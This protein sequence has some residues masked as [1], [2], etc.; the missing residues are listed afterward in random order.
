MVLR[1]L[2]YFR[3]A[4]RPWALFAVVYIVAW[5]TA[6]AW[7][8]LPWV[9]LAS[10]AKLAVTLALILTTRTL[11]DVAQLCQKKSGNGS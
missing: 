7:L 11:S 4:Q 8:W 10:W 2:R 3:A 9:E 6:L 5:L 1:L